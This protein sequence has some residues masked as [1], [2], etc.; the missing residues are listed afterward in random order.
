MNIGL[1]FITISTN[2]P[3]VKPQDCGH[4]QC[5]MPSHKTRLPDPFGLNDHLLP[6]K[7]PLQFLSMA[8]LLPTSLI[9][10]FLGIVGILPFAPFNVL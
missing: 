6:S 2:V 4:G 5:N 9:T 10:S 3:S 8:C 1:E 7:P